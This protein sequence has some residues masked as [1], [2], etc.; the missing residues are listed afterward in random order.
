MSVTF[1]ATGL[2]GGDYDASIVIASNDPD[3]P[4]VI[5][6]AHL[7]VVGVPD[8]RV[9]EAEVVVESTQNYSTDGAATTHSLVISWLVGHVG[10]LSVRGWG[11]G[12]GDWQ[13]L[14]PSPQSPA[15]VFSH[16]R[17]CSAVLPRGR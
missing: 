6:P 15:P 3:E 16:Q 17:W 10:Y 5:V 11:L 4:E 12:A 14:A 1:D 2:C 13:Q 7:H 9:A 8:I